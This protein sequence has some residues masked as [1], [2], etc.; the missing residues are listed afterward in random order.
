M[1]S[2]T[3]A[4][5]WSW[6][7]R[8]NASPDSPISVLAVMEF[9]ASTSLAVYLATQY[10]LI[11][12]GIGVVIAPLF[13]LKSEEST[14]LA[15]YLN[16][17]WSGI[18]DRPRLVVR[19]RITWVEY[20]F[21]SIVYSIALIPVVV[22]VYTF[23]FTNGN[24][25]DGV[26]EKFIIS[27][28]TFVIIYYNSDLLRFSLS[29]VFAKIYATA[30]Y[31]VSCPLKTCGRIPVNWMQN[32]AV[33]DST[34]RPELIPGLTSHIAGRIGPWVTRGDDI[35]FFSES[36]ITRP[37][38]FTYQ[39]LVAEW[40]WIAFTKKHR[41]LFHGHLD[42]TPGMTHR[43]FMGV[44]KF[45][46][47]L[48]LLP[49]T[50]VPYYILY[51]LPAISYRWSL[52]AAAFAYWPLAF[53]AQGTFT[54][55]VSKQLLEIRNFKIYAFLRTIGLC[56]V[57]TFF[58]WSVAESSYIINTAK[59]IE[60]HSKVLAH[61]FSYQFPVKKVNIWHALS[62][63]NT[64]MAFCLYFG[65][66]YYCKYEREIP[67]GMR[68]CIDVILRVI[69]FIK[70]IASI[71]ICMCFVIAACKISGLIHVAPIDFTRWIP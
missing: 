68:T 14:R 65:C 51:F 49:I 28:I 39:H 24:I 53:A 33:V 6:T 20:L 67:D 48:A 15:L 42:A 30:Y 70:C 34:V 50:V 43:L 21:R 19:G 32:V 59:N 69:I 38:I 29:C 66:D 60:L 8:G 45:F 63:I 58:L 26:F 31:A 23:A 3:K 25:G 71:Y 4:A 9:L 46:W 41:R 18:R 22:I 17:K 44:L 36:P 55:P 57:V 12:L 35:L 11:P 54:E 47:T 1:T 64:L 2:E 16:R 62:V 37:F 40:H 10:S 27:I 7:S 5:R 56:S 61:I 13:L 52:K